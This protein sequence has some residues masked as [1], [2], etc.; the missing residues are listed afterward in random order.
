MTLTLRLACLLLA[1]LACALASCSHVEKQASGYENDA[2]SS[3][4]V[5]H[6]SS[7]ARGWDLKKAAAY[8]DGREAW[9][10]SW[11]GSARDHQTFCVSCH[12]VVPYL[13]SRP[14]IRKPLAEDGPTAAESQIVSDVAKRVRL[15]KEVASYY[16]DK[17]DGPHKTAE[18]RSTEAVLNAFILANNDAQVGKVSEETRAAFA[19]MWELQLTE[20]DAKGAWLWELF[21][22]KPWESR[23]SQYYGAALAAIAVGTAPG[24]YRAAPDIEPNLKSLREYLLGEEKTQSP[25]NRL[26]LL[27]ASTKLGGLA[28]AEQR[29]AIIDDVLAKQQPDG[30]WNLSSIALTWRDLNLESLFGKWKRDDGTP[31]EVRSD[32][33]ATG[34]TLFVLEQA[35]VSRGKDQMRRGLN[36]LSEHQNSTDGS[37]T[38]YS[39]NKQRL[40][41]SN[42]GRFMSDA[43]TA[44]TVLALTE[45]DQAE[46]H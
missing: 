46:T 4:P 12:T 19:N 17:N 33:L 36:W 2:V 41:S 31:Q 28:N 23:G 10:I 18:S 16:D 6:G 27:W 13:V 34:F 14:A 21:D 5:S 11:Q 42:A 9:W 38:A 22:L 30:G 26:M 45:T 32:A 7:A 15:W 35:G 39:L 43:A 8:L 37:W 40:P 25:L 20:G 3:V 24:E 29:Q 44:F 1:V